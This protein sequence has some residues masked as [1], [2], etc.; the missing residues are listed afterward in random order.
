MKV[1]LVSAGHPSSNPRLVKE[2]DALVQAGHEVQVVH[3]GTWRPGVPADV[4]LLETRLWRVSTAW[5]GSGS[6]GYRWR[7]LIQAL[8]WRAV[9]L[10]RRIA[11]G[12]LAY[13]VSPVYNVLKRRALAIKADIYIG[14]TLP[15]LPIVAACAAHHG[16]KYVFDIEDFHPGER[17]GSTPQDRD[18]LVADALL[19]RY[20]PSAS[21]VTAAS[22]QI[23]EEVRTRYGVAPLTVLNVF[24]AKSDVSEA[25]SSALRFYWFSQTVGPHRGLEEIIAVLATLR[26]PV[27]LELRGVCSVS[28]QCELDALTLASG[29]GHVQLRFLPSAPSDDMVKL[30]VGYT[31]GIA[32]ERN[33]CLN[34]NL[35]LSNK[36]FTYLAAGTPVILSATR[37][38]SELAERLGSASLLLDLTQPT[39]SGQ[40]LAEW[41]E[42]WRSD[43]VSEEIRR[44]YSW[45][46]CQQD[47]LR[48]IEGVCLRNNPPEATT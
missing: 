25:V 46:E 14:H 13:A 31:A 48:V 33:T 2:A 35:C 15:A 27:A 1:C 21:C 10:L 20:L 36:I 26:R 34:K 6:S 23:A 7:R 43:L 12:L 18:W 11:P 42:G 47:W 16:G 45:R 28:Y 30:A 5:D 17:E 29:E 37:A 40:A 39:M 24:D 9:P 44:V 38:Q 4:Q 32:S 22:P 41:L 3:A 8:A 19:N